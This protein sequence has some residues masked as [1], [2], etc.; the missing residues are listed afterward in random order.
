MMRLAVFSAACLSVIGVRRRLNLLQTSSSKYRRAVLR[1][2]AYHRAK[3]KSA[4]NFE[5][6]TRLDMRNPRA[7]NRRREVHFNLRM[8]NAV[9]LGL[10]R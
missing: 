7:G 2:G 8:S 10:G 5:M 3:R 6:A 4:S 9:D 1:M